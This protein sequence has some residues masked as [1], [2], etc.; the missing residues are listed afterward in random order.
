M[1]LIRQICAFALRLLRK[2]GRKPRK[3]KSVHLQSGVSCC[4]EMPPVRKVDDRQLQA[5]AREM[6]TNLENGAVFR[7]L[8]EATEQGAEIVAL[9]REASGDKDFAVCVAPRRKE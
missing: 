6:R 5:L 2:L 8:V 3:L 9:F 7:P 4:V 1:K